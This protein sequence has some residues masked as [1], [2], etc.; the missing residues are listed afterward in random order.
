LIRLVVKTLLI[1]AVVLGVLALT[2]LVQP[3]HLLAASQDIAR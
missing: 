3:P 1:F 2:D